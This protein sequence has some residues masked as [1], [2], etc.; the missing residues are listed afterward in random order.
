MYHE[1]TQINLNYFKFR[2]CLANIGDIVK[3][4]I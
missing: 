4:I 1:I 3:I 2:Q